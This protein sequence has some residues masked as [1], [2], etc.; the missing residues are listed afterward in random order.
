MANSKWRIPFKNAVISSNAAPTSGAGSA[1]NQPLRNGGLN[2]VNLWGTATS[3]V[4]SG[5]IGVPQGYC[6]LALDGV[7]VGPVAIVT[8]AVKENDPIYITSGNAL[9]NVSTSN[10][11]Y[12]FADEPGVVGA[13]T[14]IG[15][16]ISN[17]VGA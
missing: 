4:G 1:A 10:T 16:R 12:G 8:T 13:A 2:A 15:V 11:L 3:V 7:I 14:V 5:G 6:M 17:A 9:T